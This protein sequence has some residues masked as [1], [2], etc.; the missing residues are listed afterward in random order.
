MVIVDT[1]TAAIMMF[2]NFLKIDNLADW[3]LSVSSSMVLTRAWK[4]KK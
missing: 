2:L 1:M 4:I 3:F